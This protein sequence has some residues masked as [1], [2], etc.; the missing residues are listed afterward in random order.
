MIRLIDESNAE[1]LSDLCSAADF[2]ACRIYSLFRSWYGIDKDML[3][4]LQYDGSGK[5]VAALAKSGGELTVFYTDK[6]DM[7]ELME[8]AGVVGCSSIVSRDAP[9][10]RKN[11]SAVVM[12]Y[13]GNAGFKSVLPE[14]DEIPFTD[15]YRLMKSC[16]CDDLFVPEYEVFL[17]ELSHCL[18]HGTALCNY[19]IADG[20]PV[21]FCMTTALSETAAVIG[22]V[23]TSPEYRRRGYGSRCIQ[24][25]IA[26][27][28]SRDIFVVRDKGR[29]QSFYQSVGFYDIQEANIN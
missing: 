3:F 28:G 15:I 8:F 22:G 27:L 26:E 14:Y 1:I 20:I 7:D 11:S 5:A 21:S 18:R 29:N 6:A 13:N 4:W 12:K 16:R 2:T 9:D 24:G 23:C 10:G 19:I 25:L 17:P